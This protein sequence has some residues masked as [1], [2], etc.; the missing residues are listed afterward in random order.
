MSEASEKSEL[1]EFNF[2]NVLKDIIDGL[3]AILFDPSCKIVVGPTI[4]FLTSIGTK[5]IMA[6]IPYT[7]IDFKTYM[8]QI[9]IVNDGE[10]DYSLISGDTGPIVYPAGFVQ[11]YQF[12]H[13]LTKGGA[14]IV[15]AQTIFGYLFTLTVALSMLTY[16]GLPP[17]PFFLLVASKR[18]VSIYILRLFNDCFTTLAMVCVVLVLQQT[19]YWYKALGPNLVFMATCVAADIYSMAISVKMNALLYLPG[20]IVVI[21]FLNGENLFKSLITLT[22]IPIV[23]VLIGWKFLVPF[24][25]DDTAKYLRWTYLTQ[26]FKFDRKFLYEWTV[27]WRFVG[28]ETFLSDQFSNGLLIG[29][30][31]VL[32]V[33]ALTR[34][35]SPKITGKSLGVL[36]K[37][38][39]KLFSTTIS[40]NNLIVSR[41]TGPKLIMLILS[42]SNVIGILFARSLHYQFLS[43]YCWQLPFL[44]AVGNSYLAIPL[45]IGHE[46]CWNVFPSTKESSLGLVTILSITLLLVWNSK[47]WV[48]K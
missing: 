20:F 22:V 26:A 38:G 5:V 8:Q 15:A 25:N 19:A 6:N 36:L 46:Y 14:D 7:E 17:W 10:I 21:Y 24:F 45:W 44:L 41:E 2:K 47:L 4:L 16:V 30:L 18:L 29:H 31:T 40:P 3:K 43:W 1:P 37:D 13:W 28:E 39:F 35:C 32:L 27:N 11:V 42:S 23:Q 48:T 33:F 9:E 34:Y 12:I